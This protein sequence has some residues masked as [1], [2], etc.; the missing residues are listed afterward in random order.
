MPDYKQYLDYIRNTGG[1][2]K[3]EHFDED[4]EPIGPMLRKDMK[5][6]GLIV[7]KDGFITIVGDN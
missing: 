3:V 5:A 1:K 4:W 2:P 7:E 6:A